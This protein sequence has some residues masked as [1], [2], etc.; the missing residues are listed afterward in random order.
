MNPAWTLGIDHLTGSIEVGKMADIVIW[1]KHPFSVYTRASI[2]L[3]D[4]EIVYDQK[5]PIHKSDFELGLQ[6][7]W[8]TLR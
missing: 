1:N 8:R 4:G 2:V 7:H 3:I 5:Q 6:M